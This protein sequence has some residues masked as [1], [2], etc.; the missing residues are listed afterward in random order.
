MKPL[1]R[2]AAVLFVL[3]FIAGG[4]FYW[5]PIWVND[6]VTRYHLWR[7]GVRSAYV[8][9]GG[10]QLHYFEGS[11]PDGSPG[12]PLLLVHG[13]GSRGED[14]SPMMPT[15]MAAGF[16]VY[17]PDLL[18]YGRSDKPGVD[19]SVTLEESV[20]LNFMQAVHLPRA[21][22]VGY[23]MGGW[24][25]AKMVLDHPAVVDRLVFYDSAGLTF[26]PTFP[27]NA[28]VP[29]DAASLQYLMELLTPKPD[30]LPPF[31]VRAT[32]RKV[33]HLGPIVQR[34]MDSMESGAD[35]LDARIRDIHAPTLIMWG[36]EDRLIPMSVGE[37]MHR[38]I[39]NSVLEGVTG[40]GH[41]APEVCP[42]PVLAGTIE[43]L[44]AQPPMQGGEKTIPGTSE[45]GVRPETQGTR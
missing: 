4:T 27:R 25:V 36:T 5:N 18:G 20:L 14:W 13:L 6:Q 3:A 37:A 10:Y 15:L 34:A 2:V 19:Y 30:Y 28:F 17:A 9:A 38:A 32:L 23:S 35:L 31:V 39:P 11:P 1:L 45:G 24:I 29:T 43:F 7:S 12:V 26:R 8:S 22:I 16:H 21:D 41:L 33:K 44:K 42:E 40:C